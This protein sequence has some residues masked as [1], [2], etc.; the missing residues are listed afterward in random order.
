MAGPRDRYEK[1]GLTESLSRIYRYPLACKE[2]AFILRLAYSKL[3]KNLQS[4][5]FQDTLTAFRLLPEMQ[6]QTAVSAVNF[7]LQGAEA[8]LPKQKRSLAVKE[9]KHAMVA[10]KRR[11]K[12]QKEEEGIAQ[13][14]QD[15]L[16]HIFSFLDLQSLVS[17]AIVCQSWNASAGDNN[18]WQSQYVIFFGHSDN[19]SKIKFLQSELD[20]NEKNSHL[21]KD[22]I[23]IDS[24]DWRYAF[25]RA[26]EVRFL[27]HLPFQVPISVGVLNAA[28][29][30]G[31]TSKKFITFSRGCC[32]YCNAIVW[33]S[34]SQSSNECFRLNC[35]NHQ[36]KPISTQ[37]VV[38]YI[39]DDSRSLISS[40]DSDSD[41][42]KG[43]ISKLWAYPRSINKTSF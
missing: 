12:S 3:P 14:P 23:A 38:E 40:S 29:L 28:A 15:V 35:K 34:D 21:R 7:L 5:I 17:A 32:R 26:Y 37:Q 16:A 31:V 22:A 39:V 25:K 4:L 41:S 19:Y 13:L 6:T 8:A 33:L 11:C 18:L 9:F 27:D 2:L 1:L 10:H 20:E 30:A 43:S 42:D 36:I 24:I